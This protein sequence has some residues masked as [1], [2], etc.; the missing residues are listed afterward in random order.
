MKD[1]FLETFE[2][3]H[4]LI[5]SRK[6]VLNCVFVENFKFSKI[7][8]FQPFWLIEVISWL[9]EN[10]QFLGQNSLPFSIPISFLSISWNLYLNFFPSL[11]DS[12][13]LIDFLVFQILKRIQISVFQNF[14]F[15]L[16]TPLHSFFFF[17][18]VFFESKVQ[19]FSSIYLVWLF[20][21]LLFIHLHAFHAFCIKF[22]KI[23][24]RK[25]FWGFL[26]FGWF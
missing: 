24:K 1:V 23:F 3:I 2:I 26:C 11:L 17:F 6:L 12:S 21:P 22:L 7:S 18:W 13:R 20:H 25:D 16:S 19:R 15:F 5:I 8:K 14:V 10:E 9:I 4:M